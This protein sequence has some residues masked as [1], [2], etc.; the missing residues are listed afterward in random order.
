MKFCTKSIKITTTKTK[1]ISKS[2]ATRVAASVLVCAIVVLIVLK[3]ALCISSVFDGLLIWAKCVLPSLLPFM[4]FT[5]ILTDLNFVN[6]LSKKCGKLTKL[7]FNAPSISAYVFLMSVISGYPVGAK[8]ISEFY[9]AGL[10]TQKQANKLT[11][12]C[13]TSGP[14]FIVGSVGTSMFVNTKLGYILFFSHILSS[15]INGILYRNMHKDS[16]DANLQTKG[17]SLN[18]IL[19]NSM[20][21]SITSCMIVGG[22]IAIF[23]LIIDLLIDLNLFAPLASLAEQLF[24]PIGITKQTATAF[25]GGIFEISKGCSML[26]QQNL[27]I[28]LL[29]TL[30]SFLI[31]FGGV[32]VFF[33]A[34]TFL[35]KCKV[36]LWFYLLQ[37]TTHAA[38]SAAITFLSCLLF[39]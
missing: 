1:K 23:F 19:P 36:N 32:S 30:A 16:F 9:A 14:L 17:A 8:L 38:L 28:T 24:A 6:K 31:S 4:L 22:Y 20:S 2:G 21:S 15:I 10:I 25:L 37:K 34:T 12:F 39:M 26:A 3:P 7:L 27:P 35:S 13:S 18:E 11:T 5:K 33:Q 29:G